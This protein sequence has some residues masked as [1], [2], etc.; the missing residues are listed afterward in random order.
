[1]E[2]GRG[3]SPAEGPL[4]RSDEQAHQSPEALAGAEG[5]RATPAADRTIDEG[6]EGV[7][8]LA[9]AAA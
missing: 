3:S 5:P 7:L 9:T 1:M 8:P 6:R 2:R 4:R